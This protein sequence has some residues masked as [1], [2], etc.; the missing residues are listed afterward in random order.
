MSERTLSSAPFAEGAKEKNRR[1]L[2]QRSRQAGGLPALHSGSNGRH[3]LTFTEKVSVAVPPG[4]TVLLVLP[5]A[6]VVAVD[7]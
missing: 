5:H 3:W 7:E 2:P 1:A 4:A 6:T